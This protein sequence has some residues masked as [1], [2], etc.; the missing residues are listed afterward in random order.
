MQVDI[1]K[2]LPVTE[3]RD[4]FNKIIDEVEGSDHLY[5]LTKNGK[6]SAVIVGVN[7][8]EKLTGETHDAI[9]QK[10]EESNTTIAENEPVVAPDTTPA[11]VTPPPAVAPDQ[12]PVAAPA[13]TPAIEDP[14][15]MPTE[16][17]KDRPNTEAGQ[18]S[19]PPPPTP[20][21]TPKQ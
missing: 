16:T 9:T 17:V 8:L 14:F 21:N 12:T 6:P 2:I 7:H 15:A 1:E 19:T 20:D 13:S 10:V 5:V 3:A 4:N 11:P 18:A